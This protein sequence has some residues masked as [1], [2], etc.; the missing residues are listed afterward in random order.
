M[1]IIGNTEVKMQLGTGSLIV[2]VLCS[3]LSN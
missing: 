3:R 1:D 2:R